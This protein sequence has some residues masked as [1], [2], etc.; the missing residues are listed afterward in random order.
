MGVK[1]FVSI[2]KLL[3]VSGGMASFGIF[4]DWG[5]G[6]EAFF[7][8]PRINAR[9]FRYVLLKEKELPIFGRAFLRGLARQ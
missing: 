2:K 6:R 7:G 3:I 1:S 4:P 9:F 8:K 5:A